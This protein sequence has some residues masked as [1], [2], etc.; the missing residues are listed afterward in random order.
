[1][2][3]TPGTI[4][5]SLDA[6]CI[7]SSGDRVD[8]EHEEHEEERGSEAHRPARSRYGRIAWVA[9]AGMAERIEAACGLGKGRADELSMHAGSEAIGSERGRTGA[10]H[11]NADREKELARWGRGEGPADLGQWRG[12]RGHGG[13]LQHAQRR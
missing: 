3:L 6:A 2:S 9:M 13:R 8:T 5:A 11:G 10:V 7:A 4:V 1:M 12:G